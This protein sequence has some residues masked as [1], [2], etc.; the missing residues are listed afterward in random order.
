MVSACVGTEKSDVTAGGS[1]SASAPYLWQQSK[2]PLKVKISDAYTTQAEVDAITIAGE[3]WETSTNDKKNFFEF[4]ADRP[5]ETTNA[6]F[7]PSALNDNEMIVY[8]TTSWPWDN[9]IL[10]ITQL[11]GIRYNSGTSSEYVDIIHADI[12]MNYRDNAIV[13]SGTGYDL[14]TV[15]LHEF[16]HFLGLQHISDTPYSNKGVSIMYP[17]IGQS[18]KRRTPFQ[19]DINKLQDLYGIVQGLSGASASAASKEAEERYVPFDDGKEVIIQLEL[20]RDG[21][22]VHKENGVI[23]HRH[24][25]PHIKEI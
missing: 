24:H 25:S 14:T 16:G 8:R 4:Q 7:S 2:F 22:C 23:V 1:A 20:R 9:Y 3:Q 21:E 5:H 18:D 11:W 15:L 10:A 12:F 13:S 19:Y 6:N 17:S